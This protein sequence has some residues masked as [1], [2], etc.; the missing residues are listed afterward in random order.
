MSLAIG[1]TTEHKLGGLTVLSGWLPIKEKVKDVCMYSLVLVAERFDVTLA[2]SQIACNH[3]SNLLGAWRGRPIGI[4]VVRKA[5]K[6]RTP[7]GWSERNQGVR[8]ARNFLQHIPQ[9][10]SFGRHAG[11]R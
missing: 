9:L 4:A 6:G 7:E 2:A 10:G 8:Q 5:V 1:L 11:N 3:C